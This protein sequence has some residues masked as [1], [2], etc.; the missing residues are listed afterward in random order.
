MHFLKLLAVLLL[1]LG[2]TAQV[3]LFIKVYRRL[4]SRWI[5]LGLLLALGSGA[6]LTFRRALGINLNELA[7]LLFLCAFGLGWCLTGLA[8]FGIVNG[9]KKQ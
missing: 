6:I 2:T 4:P 9:H 5:K 7:M 8:V 3:A 1:V